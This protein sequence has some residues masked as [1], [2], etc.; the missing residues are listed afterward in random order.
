MKTD[1]KGPKTKGTPAMWKA[2]SLFLLV[3][4][5]LCVAGEYV[6]EEGWPK[7]EGTGIKSLGQVSGIG[8]NSKGDIVVFSRA[9]RVWDYESF[10]LHDRILY[11]SPIQGKH[12]WFRQKLTIMFSK[13]QLFW[14][15]M[16][17]VEN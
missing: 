10:D 16:L 9:D 12:L 3:V 5:L 15:S 17:Q 11:V 13:D 7:L 2:S 4:F 6:I 1:K 8:V 14:P